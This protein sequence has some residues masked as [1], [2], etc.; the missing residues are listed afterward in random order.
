MKATITA[1]SHWKIVSDGSL[2]GSNTF[3]LV[4]PKLQGEAG[5]RQLKTVCLILKGLETKVNRTCGLH[6]HFDASNFEL[7]TW[8]NLFK[9]YAKIENQI[10]SFM[11]NSRR[12]NNNN[13]CR[14]MRV[15]NCES[16]INEID[17][18]ETLNSGLQKIES[19]INNGSRYFKLNSQSYWRQ[20]SIEFRQHNGTVNEKKIINWINFLARLIEYSKQ[21]TFRTENWDTLKNFL[22][23]EIINFYENRRRELAA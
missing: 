14:S 21:A 10:D 18:T 17:D 22:P 4:S 2:S 11:P 9:N 6:I 3:E 5:I 20:R 1:R 16:K 19:R 8:K 13:Y 23:D 12:N 7:K 15:S